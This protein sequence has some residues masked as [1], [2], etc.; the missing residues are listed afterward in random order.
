MIIP[1][2]R[3]NCHGYAG[4]PSCSSNRK[5]KAKRDPSPEQSFV[6]KQHFGLFGLPLLPHSG[7][8]PARLTCDLPAVPPDGV[9]EKSC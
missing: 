3:F 1:A 8:E 6:L 7:S 9:A 4:G 5:C 2:G